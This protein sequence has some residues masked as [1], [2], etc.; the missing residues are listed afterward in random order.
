MT[1]LK[2]EQMISVLLRTGVLLA[3]SVVLAGGVYYVALHGGETA[4]YRNFVAQSDNDRFVS[5]IVKGA[6]TLRPRST[7]QVGILLLI[8]TPIL[9][10]ATALV[11]FVMERDRQYA[12]ISAIVLALLL[13]SCRGQIL[14]TAG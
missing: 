6:V 7:I 8:A 9:R 3:G 5:L 1:D 4:D 13:F 11:G 2:M 14:E 12:I 10:S